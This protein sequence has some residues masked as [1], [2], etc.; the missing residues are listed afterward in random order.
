[1]VAST[2]C[3]SSPAARTSTLAPASAIPG[4]ITR[5]QDLIE[6]DQ[7]LGTGEVTMYDALRQVRGDLFRPRRAPGG[8][9]AE[10][11]PAVYVNEFY[12][13]AIDVLQGLTTDV[14]RDVQVVRSIDTSMRFGRAHPAG[15]LLVRLQLR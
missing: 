11:L 13:G 12:Q 8:T 3:A 1:M 2:A 15:A 5:S 9:T 6:R 10:E 4:V 7:L 14:V